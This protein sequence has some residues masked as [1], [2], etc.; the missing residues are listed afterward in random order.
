MVTFRDLR[1]GFRELKLGKAP[2]IVHA[3]LSA[4]GE[5]QGGAETVVGALL[6]RFES[7]IT[8]TFTYRTMITPPVGPPDNGISYGRDQAANRRA[9]FYTPRLP[10]D[11]LMGIIPETIRRHPQ[12]QRSYHPLYSFTG[13]NAEIALAAQNL[14]APYGP[15]EVLTQSNGWVLLMGVDH[16]ANTSIHYAEQIAGRRQF[17]RWA[18]TPQGIMECHHWPNCSYGFNRIGPLIE[19]YVRST[20]I[21]NAHVQAIPLSAL[22]EQATDMIAAD[23]AALLCSQA[24]C[25]R[26][27]T[28]RKFI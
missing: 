2:V 26:C 21:G 7:L 14:K 4:F 9:L 19:R 25:E 3:S 5:V 6:S 15:I 10:A 13:I 28:V 16:V 23:P 17:I 11:P 27:T 24:S 8:P 18:L 12:A 1:S 20:N 22:M